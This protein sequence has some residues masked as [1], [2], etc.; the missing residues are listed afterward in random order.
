MQTYFIIEVQ[1]N[2]DGTAAIPSPLGFQVS[3][4]TQENAMIARFFSVCAAAAESD[5]DM[6]TVKIID[7]MGNVWKEYSQT[8]YHAQS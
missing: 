2:N 5:C 6:H 3:N 7:N 4:Q 8:L 1:A